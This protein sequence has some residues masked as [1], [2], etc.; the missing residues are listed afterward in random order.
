[1]PGYPDHTGLVKLSSGWL[2]EQ[3]G[4]KGKRMNQAACYEK[5]ALVLINLG[6]ATGE[7]ILQLANKIQEDVYLKFG[8][9]LEPEV[10]LW[11]N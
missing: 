7:D 9:H 5:Q 6:K 8:L 2:I 3:C 1:M 10:N 4:W 11:Y